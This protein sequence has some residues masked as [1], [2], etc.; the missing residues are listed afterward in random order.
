MHDDL[1]D[2]M[3]Y[4]HGAEEAMRML[5]DYEEEPAPTTNTKPSKLSSAEMM[6]E[7]SARVAQG[8]VFLPDPSAQ[9]NMQGMRGA[10]GRSLIDEATYKAMSQAAFLSEKQRL[11]AMMHAQ[12]LV[13]KVP[14]DHAVSEVYPPSKGMPK[15][16][17]ENMLR[18]FPLR[19]FYV[20]DEDWRLR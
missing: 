14:A 10:Y 6:F 5:S 20:S 17:F 18:G 16:A 2:G 19:G 11:M 1:L 12:P 15:T 4:L 7:Y 8:N 9:Y 3:V 13:V